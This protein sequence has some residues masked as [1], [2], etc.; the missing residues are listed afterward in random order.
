MADVASPDELRAES[1]AIG[2]RFMIRF[3]EN[4]LKQR[5]LWTV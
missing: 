4:T 1:D 3:E 5:P 2:R